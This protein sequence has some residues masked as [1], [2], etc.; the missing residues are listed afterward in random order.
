VSEVKL[1]EQIEK[2]EERRED[3]VQRGERLANDKYSD[4]VSACETLY[5]KT[6]G[7]S[8]DRHTRSAVALALENTVE[9]VQKELSNRGVATEALASGD[10]GNFVEYGFD[11]I[12]AVISTTVLDEVATIQPMEN[13]TGLVF[14]LDAV[15][16][17]DVGQISE[18]DDMFNAQDTNSGPIRNVTDNGYFTSERQEREPFAT[19]DNATTDFSARTV[20]YPPIRSDEASG[21]ITIEA[22]DSGLVVEDDGSG[23]LQGDGSGTVNYSTG[24]V[25]VT[26]DSAPATDEEITVTYDTNFQQNPA[27]TPEVNLTIREESVVAEDRRVKANWLPESEYELQQHHGRQASEELSAIMSGIVRNEIDNQVLFEI[28]DNAQASDAGPFDADPVPQTLSQNER[29]EDVINTLRADS[30]QIEDNNSRGTGNIIIA[31]SNV[32]SFLSTLDDFEKRDG[33]SDRDLNGPHVRGEY[34]DFTVIKMPDY[35]DGKYVM[36]YKGD[37]W[38]DAGYAWMPY[39]PLMKTRDYFT[40]NGVQQSVLVTRNAR[41]QLR[42]VFVVNEIQNI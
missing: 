33:L 32:S 30:D 6:H 41:K 24:E 19:G 34:E 7:K 26:F 15:Y 8:M 39:M 37:S 25:D 35:P 42:D 28:Y 13:K 11:V 14:W 23:N 38:L 10:L 16:G 27:N 18:G 2:A 36:G 17:S 29:N 22:A 12:S 21:N 1:E 4:R 3:K 5:R 40:D 31:S 9:G 20:R